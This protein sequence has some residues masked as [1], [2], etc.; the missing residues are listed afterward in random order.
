[1][2][3]H[4]TPCCGEFCI[5]DCVQMLQLD[6][7]LLG[8][9]SSL[10]A[11]HRGCSCNILQCSA[12]ASHSLVAGC[13]GMQCQ[14]NATAA[15]FDWTQM[16]SSNINQASSASCQSQSPSFGCVLCNVPL[17]RRGRACPKAKRS[18]STQL[19]IRR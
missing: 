19:K 9:L 13:P 7:L 11:K 16:C 2:E 5:C 6:L 8:T 18:D 4:C 3:V 17:R 10:L 15:V 1:M 12:A 14:Y